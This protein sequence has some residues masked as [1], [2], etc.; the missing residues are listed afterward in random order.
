[1]DGG[2]RN[3]EEQGRQPP[4]HGATCCTFTTPAGPVQLSFLRDRLVAIC[5]GSADGAEIAALHPRCR[6]I[7]L[8]IRAFLRRQSRTLPI[9]PYMLTFGTPFQ[10]RVWRALPG[11]PAGTTTTYGALAV[12]VGVPRG[13][14]AVGQAVGCNPL[15]VVL[16]CHRVV[17]CDGAGGF[18]AGLCWKRYLLECEGG[19]LPDSRP[20]FSI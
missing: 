1:M 19:S 14:R 2:D 12:R 3:N 16:P 13:A 8:K 6:D 11:I 4:A 15:P 10:Q 5:L 17:A 7:A 9:V 20:V 18:G